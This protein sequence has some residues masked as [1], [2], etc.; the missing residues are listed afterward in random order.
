MNIQILQKIINKMNKLK[1]DYVLVGGAALVMHGL[2]R[3]TLDLDFYIKT[4][5]KNILKIFS[6]CK[7]IEIKQQTKSPY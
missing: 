7:R 2:P 4:T 3:S 6:T 5:T 1:I